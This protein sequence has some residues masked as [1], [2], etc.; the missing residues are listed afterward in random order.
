[1]LKA[2]LGV[3][4]MS[5]L[6]V[7]HVCAGDREPVSMK[8]CEQNP[9]RLN[10]EKFLRYLPENPK[11]SKKQRQKLNNLSDKILHEN[12]RQYRAAFNE[13]LIQ[14]SLTRRERKVLRQWVQQ[15][16]QIVILSKNTRAHNQHDSI[17]SDIPREEYK[18]REKARYLKRNKARSEKYEYLQI[19]QPVLSSKEHVGYKPYVDPIFG[20]ESPLRIL[21]DI[22][23][24]KALEAYP[25][26]K[27]DQ[28]NMRNTLEVIE[29]IQKF[30][31]DQLSRYADN[32]I[33]T[34]QNIHRGQNPTTSE[35]ISLFKQKQLLEN[36]K[37]S[38]KF[39]N[40]SVDRAK[41][42]HNCLIDII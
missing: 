7:S 41:N 21:N 13:I 22:E 12:K 39:L 25:F 14:Y 31:L 3:V 27:A 33:K 23:A 16:V 28:S 34:L 4:F 9:A 30:C 2:I 18:R 20:K 15:C 6:Y 19:P 40:E 42:R 11:I 10:S 1:M 37:E 24:R 38:L 29:R 17:K 8:F 26:V 35:V 32:Q 36:I 5:S